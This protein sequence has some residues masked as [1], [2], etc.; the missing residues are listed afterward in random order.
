MINYGDV[1]IDVKEFPNVTHILDVHNLPWSWAG[2][3]I[4]VVCLT[5]LEH[6]HNPYIAL[7]EMARVLA[8]GGRIIIVV[9]NVHY[10][11][12]LFRSYRADLDVLN[13]ATNPP[14]HKQAWDL[15]EMRNLAVQCGLVILGY[16]FL[17]WL[18]EKKRAPTLAWK[19]WIV[20]RLPHFMRMTEVRFTLM[21]RAPELTNTD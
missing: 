2:K 20:R 21:A 15:V 13:G 7:S 16:D 17:D 1:R 18:P 11:R 14:D 12:R 4:E 10:W 19:R 6:F 3:Y 5:A 9:P 8:P